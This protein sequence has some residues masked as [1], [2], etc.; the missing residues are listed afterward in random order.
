MPSPQAP[1]ETPKDPWCPGTACRTVFSADQLEYEGEIISEKSACPDSGREY[2][3]VRFF[4]YGNEETA[5]VDEIMP[6]KGEEARK[7]QEARA[8]Q[9][10]E[11]PAAPEQVV[12]IPLNMTSYH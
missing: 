2:V 5:W 8:A 10:Q 1:A 4:G 9:S 11:E 3:T 7:E 12:V 6:S